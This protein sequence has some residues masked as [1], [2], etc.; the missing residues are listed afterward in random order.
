MSNTLD[1]FLDDLQNRVFEDT[2]ENMGE[3]VYK[4]WR[5]PVHLK[6]MDS[7][8]SWAALQGSCGDTLTV[9]LE[10]KDDMVKKAL[11][12]TTGCGSSQV[13]GEVACEYAEGKTV[14]EAGLIDGKDVLEALGGLPEEN[15]HCAYLAAETLREAVRK[16]L[17]GKNA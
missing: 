10:I 9:Y 3:E 6:R 12:E 14:E 2:L 16:Y 7:P 5:N 17:E 15:E 11:F 4:R 8:S 1:S 13:S